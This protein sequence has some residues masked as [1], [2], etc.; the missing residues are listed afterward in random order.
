MP[1]YFRYDTWVK[2]AQGPAVAGA[3]IYVCGQ[4]ANV[5]TAPPSPLSLIYADNAGLVPIIQPILTDGFGHADFYVLAGTYTVVVAYGAVI[6]QV[7]PDQSIAESGTVPITIALETNG[8]PNGNQTLQNLVEGSNISIVDDGLG[9]ITISSTGGGGFNTPGVGGFWSNG[10][11]LMQALFGSA[12]THGPV[13]VTAYN[14]ILVWQVVI[15]STWSINDVTFYNE[16][17]AFGGFFGCGLYT[18]AGSLIFQSGG[19]STTTG[20]SF[21]TAPVVPTLNIGPGIYYFAACA[22]GP[23]VTVGQFPLMSDGGTVWSNAVNSL[24]TPLK[25]A[26]AA[27]V[28]VAGVMPSTINPAA[29][30]SQIANINNLPAVLFTP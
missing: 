2:T 19:L 21:V 25:I 7:Y 12:S 22:T 29:F 26:Y 30:T 3:Q 15:E 24:G 28:S 5:A 13:G 16:A 11:T 1:S 23:T 20:A 10:L 14:Q 17:N 9:D 6:Q 4:P 8:V 18:T 27:E